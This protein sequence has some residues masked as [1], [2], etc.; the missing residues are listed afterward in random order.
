MIKK[1]ILA[2]LAILLSLFADDEKASLAFDT[3][4]SELKQFVSQQREGDSTSDSS[5]LLS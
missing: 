3:S 5:I 1:L 2:C 4:D